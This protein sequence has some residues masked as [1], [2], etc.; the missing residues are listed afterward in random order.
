MM[1]STVHKDVVLTKQQR[2]AVYQYVCHCD[3][4]YIGRTSQR[5]QDRTKQH[6]PKALNTKLNQ[7]V[8][9]LNPILLT[10]WQRNN[11]FSTMKN[12]PLTTKAINFSILA[13]G[14]TLFHLSTL[15]ATL[16]KMLQPALSTEKNCLHAE[17]TSLIWSHRLVVHQS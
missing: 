14:R 12:A 10:L 1:L 7:I 2:L 9:Y 4:R 6:I 15:E 5:L 3:C 11:T 13:K 16:I 8:T 17:I